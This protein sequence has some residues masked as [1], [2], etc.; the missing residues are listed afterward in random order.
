MESS[1]VLNLNPTCLAP[2]DAPTL[3]DMKAR[4]LILLIC[5][6]LPI[7]GCRGQG[8]PS[9]LDYRQEMRDFVRAISEDAAGINPSFV[10]IPQNGQE[11]ITANG[12]SDG[13]LVQPYVSAIDGVGREDLFYGFDGDN[14]PTPA[15]EISYLTGFLDRAKSVGLKVLVADYCWT[16]TYVDH[17]YAE[18][19]A[20]SYISFAANRRPLDAIPSYPVNPFNVNTSDVTSLSQAKNF[21]YMINTDAYGT[22]AEFLAALQ[23]TDYDL[24]LIDAFFDGTVALTPGDVASLKTKAAGGSRLV[25]AYMSIGEAEDYRSYWKSEW[26]TNPPEWLEEENPNWPGNYKVQYWH[27][28]WQGLIFGDQDSYLTRILDAGFDGVYLDIIDGFEYF[29]ERLSSPR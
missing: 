9:D 7:I 23:N 26:A 4:L 17:S 27:D 24:L 15:E 2:A 13:S 19:A 16:P 18:S 25:V 21:L 1:K 29:E 14:L 10:V 28:E 8:D 6:A 5:M 20:R 11:L 12:E 22:K 3:A